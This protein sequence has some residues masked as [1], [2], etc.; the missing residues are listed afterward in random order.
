MAVG[1]HRNAKIVI[2]KDALFKNIKAEKDRL[3]SKTSLFAVVK[4][5]AYGHGA[6]EVAEIAKQAGASG[7]CVAILDE[8][9]E[10][11]E[12]GFKDPILVLGISRVEDI[13][14]IMNNNI[15]IS[16]SSLAWIR[17]ATKIIQTHQLNGKLKIH[18]A[19]DTGMGRIGFQNVNELGE[20]TEYLENSNNFDVEGIFTHFSTADSKDNSYF[21]KQLEKFKSMKSFLLDHFAPK[22]VHVSNS[23]TSLWHSECNG[24]MIRFGV[25]M[26][27]LNP[28]GNDISVP[29]Q[30]NPVLSLTSEIVHCKLVPKG[31]AIGYGATYTTQKDE[32]IGTVPVGYA[33]GFNRKMQG[34]YVLVDGIKCP[35]VGRVCMDQFMIKLPY[36]VNMGTKVVIIGDS[37]HETITL[38]DIAQYCDTIHYE[39]SCNLSNRLPRF[40]V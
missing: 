22:Y 3:D 6:V 12:A 29:Y 28:S 26:Y 32:W 15:S 18:I 36:E 10:L 16:V 8:A 40:Y 9:L 7:F 5:N 33:D 39:V 13:E 37:G 27:G 38:F 4:A 25:A 24:N 30:L 1:L 14:L 19:L 31:N 20:F 2:N 21:N 11:R 23:A 17:E 34:F 35:I